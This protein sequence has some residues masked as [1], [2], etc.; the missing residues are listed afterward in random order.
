M[1]LDGVVDPRNGVVRATENTTDYVDANNVYDPGNTA[2]TLESTDTDWDA[3]DTTI[4][5]FFDRKP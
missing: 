3:N 1:S 2:I 5:Y 4:V